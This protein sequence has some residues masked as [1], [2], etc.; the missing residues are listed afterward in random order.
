EGQFCE[1]INRLRESEKEIVAHGLSK[2]VIGFSSSACTP[3]SR[4][5]FWLATD[6]RL[7]R[8]SRQKRGIPGRRLWQSFL[9][10]PSV[11]D[12]ENQIGQENDHH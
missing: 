11:E 2:F 5:M 9:N 6:C 12:T 10:R 8:Y 7:C 4:S 3:A 1:Q